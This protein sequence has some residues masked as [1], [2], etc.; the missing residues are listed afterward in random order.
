MA[1][2][3]RRETRPVLAGRREILVGED[4][5]V[6]TASQ[7]AL[8]LLGLTLDELRQLP[9]GSLSLDEDRDAA[10]G[11]DEA[12]RAHGR[13]PI[14]GAGT[15]RL[16]G[17]RLV[18][19]RYLVTPQSDGTYEII[20]EPTAEPVSRPPR[21]YTIGDVLSAWRAAERQ[22]AVLTE[23]ESEWSSV[24]DEIAY[25]RAEYQRLVRSKQTSDA[26]EP[27]A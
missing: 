25:F 13:E 24:Q 4:S 10:V 6:L 26:H 16:P 22:L 15:I 9:R 20:L 17:G 23:T 14:L 1:Q 3:G 19:V 7:G 27:N 12:W 8:D 21:M 2:F 5:R 11:F 18:R